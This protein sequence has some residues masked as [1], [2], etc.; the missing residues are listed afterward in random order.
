MIRAYKKEEYVALVEII[1]DS[2]AGGSIDSRIENKFGRLIGAEWWERKATDILKEVESNPA[3]VYIQEFEGKPAGFITT[4]MDKR[5]SVGRVHTLAI[6]PKYQ[7]AGFGTLLLKH[8]LKVF[9]ADGMKLARI[10]VLEDNPNAY[11]LYKKLGFEEAARQV[12]L[13]MKLEDV[14]YL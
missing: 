13:V 12:H 4:S 3:G 8:A 9:K 10:E 6:L 7:G 2:F 14:N 11:R 1:R 5:F